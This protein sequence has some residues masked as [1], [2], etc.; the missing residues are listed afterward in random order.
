MSQTDPTCW[1]ALIVLWSHE[2]TD[3]KPGDF[4]RL[5]IGPIFEPPSSPVSLTPQE[6]D[7]PTRKKR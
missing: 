4:E 5:I 2:D 1:D 7:R 3:R 6:T